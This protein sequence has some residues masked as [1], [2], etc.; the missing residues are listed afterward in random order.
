MKVESPADLPESAPQAV[1]QAVQTAAAAGLVYVTD[2]DPGIRRVRRGKGFKY[3]AKDDKEITAEKELQRIAS[4][5]IPPAYED[6]WICP[7]PRG[8]LQATARDA[9]GRKQ[10]R[11]HPEWSRARDDHKHSRMLSFGK[12]LGRLRTRVRRDLKLP[13]LPRE[14]VL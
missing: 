14:K 2:T 8:H 3:L 9:R 10:Y 5:A 1:V 11:Y 12:A 4:L 7:D 13:G 6:V